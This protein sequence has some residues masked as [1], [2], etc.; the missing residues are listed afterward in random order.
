M[1]QFSLST[2]NIC[3]LP[4]ASYAQTPFMSIFFFCRFLS[5]LLALYINMIAVNG[6]ICSCNRFVPVGSSS[7]SLS[8]CWNYESNV[9]VH[10][11]HWQIWN[12]CGTYATLQMTLS[13][14]CVYW[15]LSHC[16]MHEKIGKLFEWVVQ[17]SN[18]H[19]ADIHQQT[20]CLAVWNFRKNKQY[21]LIQPNPKNVVVSFVCEVWIYLPYVRTQKTNSLLEMR[22]LW[23]FP[24]RCIGFFDLWSLW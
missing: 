4:F 11:T 17:W 13:F 8:E 1:N 23:D 18:L 14:V 6:V 3:V 12:K 20:S 5:V 10:L 24:M 9:C 22:F 7:V 2:P 16:F 21:K 15:F 19:C